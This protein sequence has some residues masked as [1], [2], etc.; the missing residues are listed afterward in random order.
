VGGL[1][2]GL[3]LTKSDNLLVTLYNRKQ[4]REYSPYMMLI[5]II[6][7]DES[8]QSP[9]SSV[10]LSSGQFVV[11]HGDSPATLIHRVCI[12]DANGSIVQS[13]GGHSGSGV[14]QFNRPTSIAVDRH[15]NVQ[16]T[17]TLNNRVVLLSL[18]LSHLGY[19]KIPGG[20][21]MNHPR[22]LHI[23]RLNHRL[24]IG[25]CSLDFV[26]YD[27]KGQRVFSLAV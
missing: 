22:F 17:Y 20:Y 26:D 24:Y 10:Q 9:W 18:T 27:G 15:G 6:K 13:Y 11:S 14:A 7:L 12:V 2:Y 19:V 25:E 3:S 1:C 23:D 4:I 16:V 8:M 21:H 5:R